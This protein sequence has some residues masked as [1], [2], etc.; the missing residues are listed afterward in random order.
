[1][2]RNT[3]DRP[4]PKDRAISTRSAGT[5]RVAL[6]MFTTTK[7]NPERNTV[8]TG[9]SQPKPNHM[10]VSSAQMTAGMASAAALRSAMARSAQRDDPIH[11]PIAAPTAS[12]RTSPRAKRFMLIARLC[13]SSPIAASAS[14]LS[15]VSR[16]EGIRLPTATASCQAARIEARAATTASAE[17]A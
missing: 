15:T 10:V 9:V 11:T 14:R 7:G 8:T 6:A 4:T 3:F 12:A 1:M 17:E 16:G 2:C 13:H 5:A